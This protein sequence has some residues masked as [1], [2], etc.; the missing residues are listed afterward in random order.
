MPVSWITWK[1]KTKIMISKLVINN[2][3]SS[4]TH[5]RASKDS[6]YWETQR[7]YYSSCSQTTS[8][9][10]RQA[11]R[12][13][14]PTPKQN[15]YFY[16]VYIFIGIHFWD[17]RGTSYKGQ[18]RVHSTK[19]KRFLK[20]KEQPQTRP[21]ILMKSSCGLRFFIHYWGFLRCPCKHEKP[22]N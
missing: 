11:M 19:N 20:L 16:Q 7:K 4:L 6:K 1:R 12:T 18:Q 5:T 22:V 13:K 2:Y 15:Q 17:C 9:E 21:H 3:N 8:Q 10:K 14:S